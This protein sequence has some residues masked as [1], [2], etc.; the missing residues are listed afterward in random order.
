MW[1]KATP[2]ARE[3]ALR[4]ARGGYQR[5]II[6]GSENLSGSTLRGKAKSYG[7]R[8]HLSRIN[9]LDRLIRAGMQVSEERGDH[10]RRILVINLPA[11]G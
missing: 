10:N 6:Y 9:L 4:Y 5:G 8:Y 11:Q 2:E 1:T 7:G 3:I